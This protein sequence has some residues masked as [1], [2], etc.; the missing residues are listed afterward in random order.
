MPS[1]LAAKLDNIPRRR[2][3][4]FRRYRQEST[5]RRNLK[6]YLSWRWGACS[7][8]FSR[9]S[10]SLSCRKFFS[11]HAKRQMPVT[12]RTTFDIAPSTE[13]YPPRWFRYRSCAGCQYRARTFS[14]ARQRL[15]AIY[16]PTSARRRRHQICC[17]GRRVRQRPS[18]NNRRRSIWRD[19][20]PRSQSLFHGRSCKVTCE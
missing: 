2:A 5:C 17:K 1:E 14:P 11:A 6:T 19:L 13:S 9:Q 3:C 10:A 12:V 15:P 7:Q 20:Q 16:K 4:P 18:Q 8:E